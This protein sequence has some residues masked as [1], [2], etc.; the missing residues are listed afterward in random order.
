VTGRVHRRLDLFLSLAVVCLPFMLL[1]GEPVRADA[2]KDEVLLSRVPGAIRLVNRAQLDEVHVVRLL[3]AQGTSVRRVVTMLRPG[4]S[5]L[6]EPTRIPR[7]PADAVS[8]SLRANLPFH[9]FVDGS[10]TPLGSTP[11]PPGPTRTPTLTPTPYPTFTPSDTP[12][13]KPGGAA[14]PC[15]PTPVPFTPTPVVGTPTNTPN[16][17]LTPSAPPSPPPFTPRPTLTPCA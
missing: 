10:A 16:P 15:P 2:G 8:V 1:G 11:I 5:R 3:N 9:A 7:Y 12:T 14:P 17:L 13:P 4:E 6:V